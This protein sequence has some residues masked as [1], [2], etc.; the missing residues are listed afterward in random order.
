MNLFTIAPGIPFLD[1]LA[2]WWLAR[3]EAAEPLGC[4]EG[5]FLMP[6]RRSALALTEAFLRE[7][8]GRPLLL[9]R[10]AA[11]GAL[12]EAPLAMAGA[13]DL[14]P[15][16]GEAERLA[17]LTRLVMALE[18]RHGAPATADRAWLLA[19]ELARLLDEAHREGVVLGDVLPGLV[20]ADYATHWSDTLQFL[21]I[22]TAHWPEW[23]AAQGKMDAA[24]RG[25][26]LLQAQTL[27]WEAAA[28]GYP[29]VVAGTAGGV[30]ATAGL[31]R[32]VARMQGGCVVLPG[33][34][35]GMDE[36]E[37]SGLADGHPQAGMRALLAVIGATR[38]D[39]E[40]FP[41]AV[42][43]GG[44][45]ALLWRALLPAEALWRWRRDFRPALQGLE[46]L[47][48]ADQQEEAV[49]V[50]LVLRQALEVPGARA[51]LVTPD[52]VLAARGG[53]GAWAVRGGGG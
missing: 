26:R 5:L 10:I 50:A 31:M 2:R 24:E 25:V 38:G 16:V 43:D 32:V 3:P 52:R 45:A 6:T 19:A 39:V 42:A 29:V 18:G 13:L 53:G 8:E 28:P 14:P 37:W 15:A 17:A 23:L 33:V 46:R 21:Q 20:G 48:A 27:A 9:P 51:A 12:D 44:R 34:D 47:E 1:A 11:I 30:R 36:A 7:A 22:V 4:A 35:L 40:P 49:A 41:G